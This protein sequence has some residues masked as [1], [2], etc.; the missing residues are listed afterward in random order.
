MPFLIPEVKTIRLYR[1]LG[2]TFGRVHCLAVDSPQEAIKAL[3]TVIAV[4]M[5]DGVIQMLSPMQGG[6]A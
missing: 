4:M 2:T 6:L 5:L 3:C 1:V